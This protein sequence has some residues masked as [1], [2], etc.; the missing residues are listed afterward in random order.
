VAPVGFDGSGWTGRDW[1]RVGADGLEGADG[2]QGK[3]A[4]ERHDM[5]GAGGRLSMVL[6]YPARVGAVR[7]DCAVQGRH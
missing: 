1:Q 5:T 3:G 4:G 7:A 2:E 6:S